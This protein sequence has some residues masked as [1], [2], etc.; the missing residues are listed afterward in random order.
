MWSAFPAKI[1]IL[2]QAGQLAAKWLGKYH[3]YLLLGFSLGKG[4]SATDAFN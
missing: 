1:S 2:K 3:K 4:A